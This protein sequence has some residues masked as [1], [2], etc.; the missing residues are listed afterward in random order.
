MNTL[1]ARPASLSSW[2]DV[3][4]V[5]EASGFSFT[6]R[7]LPMLHHEWLFSLSDVFDVRRGEGQQAYAGHAWLAGQQTSPL[8]TRAEGRHYVVGVLFRPWGLSAFS[9]LDINELQDQFIDPADVFGPDIA[10]LTEQ[11]SEKPSPGRVLQLVESY[12]ITKLV[13]PELPP[14]IR[15][16][17]SEIAAT[18]LSELLT[19]RLAARYGMTPQALI[20]RFRQLIGCTPAQYQHLVVFQRTLHRLASHPA[21][22]LTGAGYDLGFFDQAHF[23]R[24]FRKYTGLTPSAYRKEVLAGH[25]STGHP[26]LVSTDTDMLADVSFHT[27]SG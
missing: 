4:W 25:V 23:I 12:L 27:I 14:F 7:L 20:R 11:L 24:F 17:L 8:L 22:S 1:T 6:N 18:P 2:V 21:E 15:D 19:S 9:R 5:S 3:I 13:R 26:N 16:S 10:A